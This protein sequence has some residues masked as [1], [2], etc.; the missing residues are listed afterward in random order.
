MRRPSEAQ[1]RVGV[2]LTRLIAA[3]HNEKQEDIVTISRQLESLVRVLEER[4]EQEKQRAD[5]AEHRIRRARTQP[6]T[7]W[8]R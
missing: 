6:W 8:N 4:V 7:I 2:L 1:Q 3:C 5:E